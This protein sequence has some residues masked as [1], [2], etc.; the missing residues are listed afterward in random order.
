MRRL[1]PAAG[2]LLALV[3]LPAAAQAK[4][5]KGALLRVDRSHHRVE[6][7]NARHVVRSYTVAGRLPSKLRSGAVVSFKPKGKKLSGLRVTGRTRKL[8]FYGTVVSSA[9]K[10]AVLRLSDGRS[11]KVGKKQVKRAHGSSVSISLE[12]L[13]KGQVVLI[14]M[15]TDSGG[16]VSIT[17]KLV[18]G[19]DPT[20]GEDDEAEGTVTAIDD[21]S[22]TIDTGDEEM[23][24]E[25][26]ADLLED[27]QVGDDVDVT[28]YGDGDTL[29]ADDVELVDGEADDSVV[30]TVSQVRGDGLTVQVD[31]EGAMSFE[32]DADVLEGVSVGE[33]VEVTYYQE[34]DGSLVA[35]DVE[36]ADDTGGDDVS[37]GDDAAPSGGGDDPSGDDSGSSGGPGIRR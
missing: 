36:A 11:W 27:I 16:N 5:Q 25:A 28:Y 3:L 35:D 20:G 2:A 21:T 29:V 8:T 12:G 6:I 24:F 7:V 19:H 34:D 17:I 14:T 23:T 31:G 30:G 1:L 10:G 18:K 33:L 13:D 9:K 15:V 32:A 4:P 37:S 26:D 22:I